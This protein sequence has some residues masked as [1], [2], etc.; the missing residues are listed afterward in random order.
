MT[1][2][3]FHADCLEWLAKCPPNSLH[4]CITDPPYGLI[5][6]HPDH[7]TKRRNGHG[8]VWRIPPSF[9]GSNRQPLPRFTVLTE[10]ELKKLSDFFGEWATQLIRVLV[11]GAHVF[12]ASNPLVSHWVWSS[13][14]NKGF[15]KRGE[16]IRLVRTFRGGDRPKGAEKEFADVSAMPRSAFEPWGLFRKPFEG[17]LAENLRSWKTGGLRRPVSETPFTDVIPSGRTPQDEKNIA[18]HP[19]L[20]PQ[21]FLRQLAWAALPLGEGEIVD[22][23]AGSGSTLAA[24]ESLGYDSFGIELDRE[25]FELA[26]VAVPRLAKISTHITFLELSETEI[27]IA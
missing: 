15:E 14:T 23:F 26:N 9:D 22:P 18:P 12:I 27:E 2:H 24:A 19:S 8:G 1:Y 20:K 5:E 3:L 13:L 21:K 25:Y 17:T 4:A 11:P 6:Y 16:I 10:N 7:L